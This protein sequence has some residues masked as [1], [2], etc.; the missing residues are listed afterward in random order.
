MSVQ[1]T[2]KPNVGNS[3][4]IAKDR[5]FV[6]TGLWDEGES[7][8]VDTDDAFHT[9]RIEVD[10]TATGSPFRVYYDGALALRGTS[11]SDSVAHGPTPKV[12][13]GD[14]TKYEGGVSEWEYVAHNASATPGVWLTIR[15]DPPDA[16][17]AWSTAAYGFILQ[18]STNLLPSAWQ[19]DTNTPTVVGHEKSVPVTTTGHRFFRL[20]Q[21]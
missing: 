21:P 17:V 19:D 18:E 13:W 4:Y 2:T 15:H 10:G 8:G 3:F 1:F 14:G 6:M 20:R 5:I 9:Y 11:F 16:R 7:A 12:Q